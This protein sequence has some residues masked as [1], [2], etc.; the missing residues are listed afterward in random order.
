[1]TLSTSSVVGVV[2]AGGQSRR[3]G[4]DKA[5]LPLLGQPLAAWVIAAL[6]TVVEDVWLVGCPASLARELGVA[7]APDLLP[8]AGPVAGIYS[9]LCATGADIL[10][11][12]CDTPLLQPALLR[13]LLAAAEGWD[14]VVPVN[15]GEYE[16]LLAFYRQTCIPAID[17]ALRAGQ[18]RVVSF[19]STVKVQTISQLSWQ[20]WDAE[21]LSFVNLNS[22]ADLEFVRTLLRK[23]PWKP[24]VASSTAS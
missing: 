18:R 22:P 5:S 8:G 20:V 9:G 21:G 10:V 23:S 6:R 17:E 14:V 3:M 11:S 13:G 7:Y 24:L 19:Y 1:M 12:A 2:L 16:P 4:I 15:K